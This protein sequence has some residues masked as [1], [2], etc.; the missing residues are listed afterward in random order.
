MIILDYIWYDKVVEVFGGYGEY[1]EMC[2]DLVFV[3][4]CVFN[5]GKFVLVNIKIGGSGFC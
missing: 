4:E 5:V 3:L 1:V 2:V